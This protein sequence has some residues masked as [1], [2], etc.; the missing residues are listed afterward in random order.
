[1]KFP[2]NINQLAAEVHEANQKW[3][4]DLETGAPL[5][6]DFGEMCMLMVSELSEAM[7]GER[8]DLMDD[9]LPHMK[10][11]VVEMADCAIRIM[12]TCAGLGWSLHTASMMVLSDDAEVPRNKGDALLG[13]VAEI[14]RARYDLLRGNMDS[15]IEHMN[16]A[17]FFCHEYCNF[18]GYDLWEAWAQKMD[19]NA[20]RADHQPEN[21]MKDGGKKW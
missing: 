19:Y 18:H 3:W 17:L 20:T 7:E 8:K 14:T 6:R 9:H 1:M 12:D 10:M 21:R 16:T 2:E 13:I 4:F 11:A 5:N 15:C